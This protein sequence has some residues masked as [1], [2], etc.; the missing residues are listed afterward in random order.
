MHARSESQAYYS[1]AGRDLEREII[2]AA[3]ACDTEPCTDN[4]AATE[5]QRTPSGSARALNDTSALP[6]EY[7]GSML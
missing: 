5:L 2:R 3:V 6:A 4:P 7:P 1:I